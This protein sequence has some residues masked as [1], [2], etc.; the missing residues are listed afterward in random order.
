LT[1]EGRHRSKAGHIFPVEINARYFEYDG[2]GYNL[3]LARGITERKRAEQRVALLSFALDHVGEAVFLIDAD[4]RFR[5]V[6]EEACRTLRCTR[7]E[8]LGMTV[9]ETDP[10]YAMDTWRRRRDEVSLHSSRTFESRHRSKDGRV[11]PIEVPGGVRSSRPARGLHRRRGRRQERPR[12]RG[13]GLPGQAV[14]GRSADRG[15][16]DARPPAGGLACA[17]PSAC[18]TIPPVRRPRSARHLALAV[19]VLLTAASARTLASSGATDPVAP[20]LVALAAMLGA[21]KLGGHLAAR[22]G[23]PPVLGELCAGLLLGNLD[24]LGI[25]ALDFVQND[26]SVDIVARIGIVV[27]LFEVGLE[28]TVR[29]MLRVGW[30]SLLVATLGVIAP[31][32]LG[33]GVG[34]L[35]LPDRGVYVHAFLGA[36]LTATSVGITA[37]VLRDLG[38]AGTPTA[39]VILG[40]AVIDDVQGLLV[41]AVMTALI[42]AAGAHGGVSWGGIGLTVVKA[43]AFL[44]GA[45]ALGALVTPRL[46]RFTARLEGT[47]VLLVT[48]LVFCFVLASIASVIGL[49]PIVG[50]YAAGLILEPVHLRPF[51]EHGEL[52]LEELIKPVSAFLVPVFFVLMGMRVE[53]R[54]LARPEILGLA[55]LLIAVAVAGKQ[56]C[57][58]GAFGP[59]LDRLSIGIG[60]IPRG[61]VGLIFANMG[62]GLSIRGERIVDQATYAA[63][64]LMVIVTTLLAPPAL[65]WSLARSQRH[66]PGTEAPPR[67]AAGG[68]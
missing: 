47:G 50:A 48:A 26:A 52:P 14:R 43:V 7:D 55:G 65:K 29:D 3:A 41:L 2:Q 60:M 68:G 64:V 22:L 4:A 44:A 12:H 24:L 58:L 21:A 51:T 38:Q 40:A 16:G 37:R 34:A 11:F 30:A 63:V 1:F 56:V 61:E 32:A 5:Y 28:S 31:F 67:A 8:L 17:T 23:Q 10:D 35:L 25:H 57:S 39:R 18:A 45:L 42:G 19:G 36:T 46:F 62:L 27:L 13:R 54:A 6:N 9:P 59:G 53:L 49:A 33:W 66:R 15:P 20:V